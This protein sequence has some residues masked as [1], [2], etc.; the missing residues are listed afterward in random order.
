MLNFVL[1]LGNKDHRKCDIDAYRC[2]CE[3]SAFLYAHMHLVWVYVVWLC[4]KNNRLLYAVYAICVE[5]RLT[6]NLLLLKLYNE[7]TFSLATVH[8]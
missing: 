5:I 7:Q 2:I 3:L 1:L 4:Q 6:A 8:V